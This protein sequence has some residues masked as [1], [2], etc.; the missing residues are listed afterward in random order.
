MKRES[1]HSSME[2]YFARKYYFSLFLPR[3]LAGESV[4]FCVEFLFCGVLMVLC[5]SYMYVATCEFRVYI[6]NEVLLHNTFA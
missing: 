5:S 6:G 4:S 3:T 2:I 1:M